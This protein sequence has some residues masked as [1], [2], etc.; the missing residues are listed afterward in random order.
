MFVLIN[1]AIMNIV[2][3]PKPFNEFMGNSITFQAIVDGR[4]RRCL[5]TEEALIDHFGAS[6][7]EPSTLQQ[8]FDSNRGTIEAIAADRLRTGATGDVLLRTQDF[9]D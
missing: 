8:A 7:F 6:E 2:F 5:V 9:S 1:E 4:A 3:P